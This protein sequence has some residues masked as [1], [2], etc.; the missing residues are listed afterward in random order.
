MLLRILF[1]LAVLGAVIGFTLKLMPGGGVS[2]EHR[3]LAEAI[4]RAMERGDYEQFVAHAD[5][6][7]RALKREEFDLLAAH[8]QPRLTGGH[9]LA[10]VGES[11]RSG[12]QTTRW[13]VSFANGSAE[14]TLT[15]GVRE[16]RVASFS[17]R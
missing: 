7:L 10:F 12:V 13:R 3:T 6:R 15:L 1:G 16:G 8:N 17:M 14:T 4:L 5:K 11:E 9:T 2:A